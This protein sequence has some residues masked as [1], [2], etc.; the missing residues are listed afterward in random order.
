MNLQEGEILLSRKEEVQ[1]YEI[2]APILDPREEDEWIISSGKEEIHVLITD[3][4]FMSAVRKGL[5]SF[6]H[7]CRIECQFQVTVWMT[8][9][10]VRT[11]YRIN[12]VIGTQNPDD[13]DRPHGGFQGRTEDYTEVWDEVAWGDATWGEEGR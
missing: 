3:S 11:E 1:T 10:G 9:L 6:M 2:I 8:P 5:V 13:A 7:G 12:E 4:N